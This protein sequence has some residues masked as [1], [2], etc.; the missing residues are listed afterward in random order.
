MTSTETQRGDA[1]T[2]SRRRLFEAR[3]LA[4]GGL[5]GA[6]ALVLPVVFH[7]LG[8][9]AGKVFLPMY[10]PIL[11]LGLLASWEVALTVGILVP[12][13]SS[14]L[15]GMPP[16]PTAVMMVCELAAMGV[17][18]SLVRSRG[19][20]IWPAAIAGVL[21]ARIAGVILIVTVLPLIGIHRGVYEYAVASFVAALPGEVVL[22]TIVPAAVYAIERTSMIG[23]RQAATCGESE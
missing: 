11:A 22:L 10:Y 2:E 6:L 1:A 8:P 15:T 16:P 23:R 19:G 13:I 5:F 12:I 20:G 4:L 7:A 3:D 17:V 21:T 14:V 18:A 9:V